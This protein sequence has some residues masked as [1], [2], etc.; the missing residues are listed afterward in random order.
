MLLPPTHSLIDFQDSTWSAL[1][2]EQLRGRVY[3]FPQPKPVRIYRLIAAHTPDVFLNNLAFAKGHI[4]DV[5]VNYQANEDF[6]KSFF[7]RI[8]RNY[9]NYP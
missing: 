7:N 3:R 8:A 5:F 1:D 4:H 2:D 9:T 6:R